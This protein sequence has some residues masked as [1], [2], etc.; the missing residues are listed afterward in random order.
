[1]IKPRDST[2]HITWGRGVSRRLDRHVADNVNSFSR[3]NVL[4]C[5]LCPTHRMDQSDGGT[6]E[7]G[8]ASTRAAEKDV[9]HGIALS[10]VSA[11][12]DVENDL[13]PRIGHDIVEIAD[14]K[15]RTQAGQID[16]IGV[17][18]LNEPRQRTKALPI[19]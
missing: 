8:N 4:Q 18:R 17:A 5:D 11:I 10:A 2:L 14:R 16:A 3:R 9:C 6:I 19:G 13:P 7:F 12:I 1:M 15:N